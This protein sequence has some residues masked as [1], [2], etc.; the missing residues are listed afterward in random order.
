MLS[1]H[2]RFLVEVFAAAALLGCAAAAA[3]AAGAEADLAR[4]LLADSAVRGGVVVHLGCGDGKLAAALGAAGDGYVVHGL[5]ADAANVDAARRHVQSLGLYGRV[6]VDSYSGGR[7]PYI[8]NFVNLLVA[9]RPP[10]AMMDQIMR[11]LAPGGVACIRTAGRWDKTVKPRPREMDEWTHYLHDATN[12][13]VAHDSLVGPPRHLQWVG[14]PRWSRHHDHMASMSAL[15][16]TNGRIFYI[17]DEGPRES[18]LLP[19][20]WALLARDAFNGTILWKRT[21]DEWN[22]QLWPLKSGPNQLP[23][24]LVAV[25][26]R[27]YVT[28][29]I[30]APLSVLDAATGRTLRTVAGTEH[31]DEILLSDGVLFLLVAQAPNKW[32]QYR[33]NSTY[34]WDNSGRANREWAWDQADRWVMAVSPDTGASLWKKESR[35]APLTLAADRQRIYFYDGEK[36]VSLDRKTG[37]QAWASEPILRKQAFP[38]GY[39]PT[40]VVH[41]GVVLV[42]VENSSMTALAAADG[43]KL[44]SAPHHRGGHMSPDD[45]LVIGGMV[46]S[47][48]IANGADS[49]IFTG[50]DFRT[51]EVKS[52]FPPD[53]KA[54]WFHHRCYRSRATDRYILCSR[55]GIE[56]VDVAAK[57]WSINHWVRGGCLY[58]VMPANGLVYAP[59]HSCGCYLESKLYGLNAM[60]AASAAREVP[61]DVPD[62]GR[63]VRGPAYDEPPAA[64]AAAAHDDWP[65][66]RHD[67]ARSGCAATDVPAGLKRAW[68]ADVGGRLSSVTVAEGKVFVAAV[69]THTV[70]ALDAAS[71]K[72]AWTFATGGRVD[73]PPTV[74]QGRVIFGS[75]DGWVYCVRASDGRLAWRFRAAPDERRMMAYEQLESPWPVH[76]SVLV[77]GDT[78]YAL[79]GRSAFLDGGMRLVRIDARTG[80]KLGESVIDDRDPETGDDLQMRMRGLDMP[81]ALDD[82]LS[83]DGKFV[84]MRAQAFNL[85]GVRQGIAPLAADDQAAGEGAHLFSR[86]GFLDDSWF[87]RSYWI[88]GR[89]VNSGYGGWLTPGHF[90]P[91]GRLM[92]FDNDRLYAFDRKPEYL[93]NASVAEYYVYAADKNVTEEGIRRVKAGTQKID[94]A[95]PKKNAASSDWLGRKTAASLTEQNSATFRWAAGSPPIQARAMVLAGK[96]LFLA[97]PPDV[98][99]EEEA[100]RKP[101]DPAVRARME[102]QAAALQGR[103]GSRLLAISAA[104]GKQ[105]G[106]CELGAMPVFDGM[107]AARGRLYVATVDGKVICL[108]GEGT[109]VPAAPAAPLTPLDITAKPVPPAPAAEPGAAPKAK[110]KAKA[111]ARARPAAAD[112]PSAA[113]DFAA[114]SGAAVTR[115]EMGYLLVGEAKG[116]GLAVRKLPEPLKGQVTFK[117]RMDFLADPA[118]AKPLVNGFLLFG[119]DADPARLVRCG[120]RVLQGAAVISDGP[121]P[122]GT[123]APAASQPIDVAEGKP[124]EIVVTADLDAGTVTMKA[125]AATVTATLQRRIA[126]VTHVGYGVL[127]AVTDFSPV[128]I[129]GK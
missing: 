37:Q 122:S 118:V 39:G 48:A 90:A 120:V 25:G 51:G 52:E 60:A 38:T 16:S 115:S 84:Y 68:Q 114:V 47:G 113:A 59:P 24:R 36:A 104:D 54:Y 83:S 128:D 95:S 18:I 112:G 108:G 12:N 13:A 101:D 107:A 116:E 55:T 28:L 35:V 22:T 57:R 10:P 14:S 34:V 43:K 100:F 96:T 91:C 56:F 93:C 67:A 65:A 46:W 99:D 76:G 20:K 30:D 66:Y 5:D 72:P 42:S 11:V 127:G 73:S 6:S 75:A 62:A 7:L 50:R 41:E 4:Q 85:D 94:A 32:K 88:Y 117:A 125:G 129:G 121:I 2:R 23:R 92:V 74:H 40:L 8:D 87:W 3:R 97:G 80:R 82:I 69:D 27:V 77:L 98:L 81:V 71:G 64:A 102:E 29:G 1:A 9:D 79:A 105:L 49:G 21:I 15:V 103:K 124:Q 78:V 63:L 109:A 126:A 58:G 19:S 45:L 110:A 26:D 123:A 106:A 119:D 61:R 44:W 33:P 111:K 17:M 70:H 53:I 89:G 31:T 86:S